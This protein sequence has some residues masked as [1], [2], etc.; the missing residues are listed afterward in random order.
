MFV[1]RVAPRIAGN[2]VVRAGIRNEQLH[3]GVV[4]ENFYL[5]NVNSSK[6]YNEFLDRLNSVKWTKTRGKKGNNYTCKGISGKAKYV[7]LN[8]LDPSKIVTVTKEFNG[9][10]KLVSDE[11]L[12]DSNCLNMR[13]YTTRVS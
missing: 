3:N 10:A 8:Q 13:I 2:L 4:L 12:G 11:Y 5:D 9:T 6:S 7:P 1:K